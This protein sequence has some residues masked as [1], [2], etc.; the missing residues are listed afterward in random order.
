MGGNS[1]DGRARRKAI[2]MGSLAFE[3]VMMPA[4]GI[5]IGYYLD[6]RFSSAPYLM[7]LMTIAALFGSVKIF[8]RLRKMMES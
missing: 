6:R 2:L 1:G 4:I 3:M 5:G 8:G 7:A